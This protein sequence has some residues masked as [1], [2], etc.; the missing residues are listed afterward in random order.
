MSLSTHV[1]DAASGRP[2][3]G[4]SVRVERLVGANWESVAGGRTD[5]AGRISELGDPIGG[6][7]RITFDTG[8]YFHAQRVATFYPEVI[9]TFEVA[10]ATQHYHVPLLLS[11]FGYST[12]RGS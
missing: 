10:D 3:Q 12:Y 2:A 5:S 7:H 4:V 1:L 9:V 11:P 8:Q 6:V